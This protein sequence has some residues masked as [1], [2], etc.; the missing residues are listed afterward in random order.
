MSAEELAQK[1]NKLFD[2]RE[3]KYVP[4]PQ[5]WLNNEGWNDDIKNNISG[6]VYMSDDE[7]YRDKDGYIISKK[8]TKN[9]TSRLKRFLNKFIIRR[10]S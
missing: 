2:S 3:E 5:K 6:H 1:F 10:S 9:F 4:Y 8:N 7:V